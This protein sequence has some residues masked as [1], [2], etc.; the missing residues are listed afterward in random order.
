MKPFPSRAF[1]YLDIQR[2]SYPPPFSFSCSTHFLLENA[3][4]CL[5]T[6]RSCVSRSALPGGHLN[7]TAACNAEC[8]CLRETYSPVCGSDDVMYYSPCHAGCKEVS[9]NLRN[10]KKVRLN[11]LR[12]NKVV[13]H[14]LRGVLACSTKVSAG[15]SFAAKRCKRRR[16]P[17][18]GGGCSRAPPGMKAE[19]NLRSPC[20]ASLNV[21]EFGFASLGVKLCQNPWWIARAGGELSGHLIPVRTLILGLQ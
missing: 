16:Q 17:R 7:L 19:G 12:V 15:L 10:G 14:L 13:A 2:I 20:F 3:V 1:C 6:D 5:P 18:A 4:R 9:E 21:P 11:A 8:G